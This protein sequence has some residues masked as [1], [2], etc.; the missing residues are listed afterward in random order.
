MMDGVWEAPP[1]NFYA[2][3]GPA[4][5]SMFFM[6][7]GYLFWT[8]LMKENGRPRWIPLYVG[9]VFRIVPLYWVAVSAMIFMV[10]ERSGFELH[11]TRIHVIHE[12]MRWSAFGLFSETDV[13]LYRH[14]AG[15]LAGVTWSIQW[16]WFFYMSLP[17]LAFLA[18]SRRWRLWAIAA[19]L[20]VCL[21]CPG[22]H[23]SIPGV[24]SPRSPLILAALFLCGMLCASL[25]KE[26]WRARLPDWLSSLTV[27][28]ALGGAMWFG[29]PYSVSSSIL[30]GVAFYLIVS[31]CMVFGLLVSRP[32]RR[33]GDVSYGI[34]LLQGL[35][36][37]AV[38]RPPRFK[39]F[40]LAS[41]L[42]FWLSAT[43]CAVLLLAVAMV[44]HVAVERPGIALGRRVAG[45]FKRMEAGRLSGV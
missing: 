41:P 40:A 2:M 20:I 24:T 18:R 38:F 43:V 16:E 7:T 27:L 1:V 4:G 10:F 30:L 32:A 8:R 23:A 33:M 31:G 3:L 45:A 36:L 35:L 37:A 14:T 44:A 25:L 22:T 11:D 21:V 17:L 42:H 39:A 28:G 19:M 29:T 6:I 34:Y 13:N 26:G 15:W 9:R 12:T 5:V